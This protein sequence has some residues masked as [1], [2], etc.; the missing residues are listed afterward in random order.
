[1]LTIY[2]V[3]IIWRGLAVCSQKVKQE[4]CYQKRTTSTKRFLRVQTHP[5]YGTAEERI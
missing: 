3:Q 2:F 1:M 4:I 5:G